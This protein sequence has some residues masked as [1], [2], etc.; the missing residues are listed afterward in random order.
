MNNEKNKKARR[1]NQQ[2]K[3]IIDL[4]SYISHDMLNADINGSYTGVTKDS[5]FGDVLDEP[6]QD[7]DDL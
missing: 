3:E 4:T 2:G 7:A 5:Y 6:V 1:K